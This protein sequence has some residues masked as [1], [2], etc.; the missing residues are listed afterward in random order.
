VDETLTRD[1]L[2]KIFKVT[3]GTLY[4]W[5]KEKSDFPRPFKI[6]RRLLWKKSDI[7]RYIENMK[8]YHT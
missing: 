3:R 5:E 4:L 6:G 1:D 2:I 8:R 7:E